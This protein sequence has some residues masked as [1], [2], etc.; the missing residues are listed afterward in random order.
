MTEQLKVRDYARLD[1]PYES[2]RAALRRL[3]LASSDTEPAHFE[4]ICDQSN[5]AGLPPSTRVTLAWEA[6]S[7]S[8][9]APVSSAEIYASALS[10]SE[11][12]LEIEGHCP[13]RSGTPCDASNG[14]VADTCIHT[15]L[16]SI[17]ER[18][19]HDID[20]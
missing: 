5:Q 6:S 15:I 4:S 9:P 3:A 2:V 20:A 7:S 19:R 12:Q 14:H 10:R 1:R 8:G 13:A 16:E 17:V 11:T 18:L